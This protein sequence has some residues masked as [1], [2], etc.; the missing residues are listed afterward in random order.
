MNIYLLSSVLISS[1]LA[2][3]RISVFFFVVFLFSSNELTTL[4]YSGSCCVPFSIPIHL[5]FFRNAVM[6]YSKL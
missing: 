2:S 1:L 6:A 3:N 5:I 4:A